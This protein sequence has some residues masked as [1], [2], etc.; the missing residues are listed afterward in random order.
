MTKNKKEKLIKCIHCWWEIHEWVKKCIHCNEW[1]SWNWFYAVIFL[2]FFIVLEI[3]SNLSIIS[4]IFLTFILF[5]LIILW[6]FWTKKKFQ[7]YVFIKKFNEFIF[8]L[9]NDIKWIVWILFIWFA[10]LFLWYYNLQIAW[11]QKEI[12][13][14]T[15]QSNN[16]LSFNLKVL[17]ED[18]E[19]KF[20]IYNW[21]NKDLKIS[22]KNIW[23]HSVKLVQDVNEWENSSWVDIYCIP[24]WKTTKESL[25]FD[26]QWWID[27]MKWKEIEIDFKTNNIDFEDNWFINI[28][29]ECYNKS[30]SELLWKQP[31]TYWNTLQIEYKKILL[32]NKK[33][34]FLNTSVNPVASSLSDLTTELQRN[35]N[36]FKFMTSNY[37]VDFKQFKTK[38]L[39]NKITFLYKEWEY[40]ES[41]FNHLFKEIKKKEEFNYLKEYTSLELS[42]NMLRWFS[43]LWDCIKLWYS[44]CKPYPSY[45]NME[46]YYNY[47]SPQML[48][49]K[50]SYI[51][52]IIVI[53][54]EYKY[55]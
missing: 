44:K 22:I 50:N 42:S 9:T 40:N 13:N 8:T 26:I 39:S 41:I 3:L 19:N 31:I 18:Y 10:T 30:K 24:D 36:T 33:I 34:L 46:I 7:K 29:L 55:K 32:Q 6:Y 20:Y 21:E 45:D 43:F 16:K 51:D 12:S 1:I 53:P 17:N 2:L 4:K 14:L 23:D 15:L 49:V 27:L 28:A 38:D 54:I 5:A 47:F 11:I 52:Y 48:D 37:K 35:W 25:L